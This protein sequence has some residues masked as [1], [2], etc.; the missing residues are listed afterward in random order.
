MVNV[1][2]VKLP[3]QVR[4]GPLRKGRSGRIRILQPEE[5]LCCRSAVGAAGRHIS[6]NHKSQDRQARCGRMRLNRR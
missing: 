4:G 5:E 1:V 3:E 2:W 6:D